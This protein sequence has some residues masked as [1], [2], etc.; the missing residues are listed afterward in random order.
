MTS[1]LFLIDVFAVHCV[2]KTKKT[3]FLMCCCS[4][5]LSSFYC[6]WLN[7]QLWSVLR[8]L[9]QFIHFKLLVSMVLLMW[10]KILEDF[11]HMGITFPTMFEI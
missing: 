9:G 5:E 6:I 10:P 3:T 1:W 11:C 7:V 8:K 2:L 4:L